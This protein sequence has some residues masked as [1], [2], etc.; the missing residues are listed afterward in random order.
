MKNFVLTAIAAVALSGCAQL[1]VSSIA[2]G[3]SATD[4]RAKLGAPADERTLA[5]GVRA[6][7][8]VAGP[9]GYTTHRI[10]FDASN[11]VSSVS[12]L[13]TEQT[14]RGIKRDES[15]RDDVLA[16]I[17]RP[18]ETM[19]FDRSQTEVWSYRYMDG[20]L[21][22]LNDVYFS[23]TTGKVRYYALYRDPIAVNSI[24]R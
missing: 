4:V 20:T 13:L 3:A 2:P 19:V 9:L 22:M 10:T 15:T 17:G 18:R 8:Y 1:F 7:D 12:Q 24:S 23:T 21:E 16:L 5:G 11:R 14:F 6:W